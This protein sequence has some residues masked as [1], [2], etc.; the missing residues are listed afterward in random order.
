MQDIVEPQYENDEVQQ[1]NEFTI[2]PSGVKAVR[3]WYVALCAWGISDHQRALLQ[4]KSSGTMAFPH[5]P[6]QVPQ[7][8]YEA[9]HDIGDG[10]RLN[11]FV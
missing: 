1:M 5:R 6:S 7:F 2:P 11:F 3:Q 9:V 4:Y 10:L 8:V